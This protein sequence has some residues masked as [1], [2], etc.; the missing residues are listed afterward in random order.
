MDTIAQLFDLSGKGAIVTGGAMGIGQAIAFR[1]AEAGA[2][3]MITD[4]D[5]NAANLTA[6]Q[7]NSQGGKARAIVADAGSSA[8]GNKA[9]QAAV[10][11]FGSLDILVNN[12]GIYPMS[13]ALKISEELMDRVLS[14]NLKGLLIYSQAAAREMRRGGH[15][16]KI[17]NIA[18]KAGLH[19]SGAAAHYDAS[20]GGVIMLTKSLALEFARY[21]ITVNV[22]APG[23][24]ITPGNESQAK[25]L[26]TTL[27]QMTADFLERIPLHRLGEPDAIAKAVLFLASGAADYMTGSLLVVDG[28]FL[29]S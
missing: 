4:I 29:L 23:G 1:L 8:D 12:A 26:G 24:I 14:I 17:V 5:L 19:P 3:V 9:V 11:A 18:S 27:E 28:G 7:I 20:K 25:S 10:Q 21:D 2:G 22:V 16:G 13:P 6:E 15:G